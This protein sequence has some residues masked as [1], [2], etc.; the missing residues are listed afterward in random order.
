MAF[1]LCLDFYCTEISETE[2]EM[3][4]RKAQAAAI[5]MACSWSLFGQQTTKEHTKKSWNQTKG[6]RQQCCNTK[7]FR[8]IP[9]SCIPTRFNEI[10]QTFQFTLNRTPLMLDSAIFDRFTDNTTNLPRAA[11]STHAIPFISN[12]FQIWLNEIDWKRKRQK[13]FKQSRWELWA[14]P[15]ANTEEYFVWFFLCP[16]LH[17]MQH[18]CTFYLLACIL[19]INALL[20]H[21]HTNNR[22][23][24][25]SS[26]CSQQFF[27]SMSN[28]SQSVVS[29]C[30]RLLTFIHIGSPSERNEDATAH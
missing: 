16:C 24:G 21:S 18:C 1:L 22:R 30:Y 12:I 13:Y 4:D 5:D 2:N 9:F 6:V 23:F 11:H 19:V 3:W 8:R 15:H 17:C 29:Q 20:S 10:R 28:D 14:L 25:L 7:Q 26:F 27:K